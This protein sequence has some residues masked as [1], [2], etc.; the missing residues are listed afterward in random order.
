MKHLAQAHAR[1]S[2]LRANL[3]TAE[4]Y[5][6]KIGREQSHFR[7]GSVGRLSAVSITTQIAH[8]ESHADQNYWAC[9]TFDAALTKVI[10]AEFTR[11]S[12][13]A[14]AEMAREYR[15]AAIAQKDGLQAALAEIESLETTDRAYTAF[16]LAPCRD[17]SVTITKQGDTSK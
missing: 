3:D 10:S 14:L 2:E 4:K 16:E 11:L 7:D 6:S 9:P 15:D 1:V 13:L 17:G 12:C 8:Q 5:I